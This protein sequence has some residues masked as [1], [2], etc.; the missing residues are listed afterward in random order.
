[1]ARTRD[2]HTHSPAPCRTYPGHLRGYWYLVVVYY[3]GFYVCN[4]TLI[5]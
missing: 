5:N 1:M 2:Y 3:C 4:K